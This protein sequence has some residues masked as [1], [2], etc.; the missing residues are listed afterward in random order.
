VI[1]S[2]RRARERDNVSVLDGLALQIMYFVTV[3]VD[4]IAFHRPIFKIYR[5]PPQHTGV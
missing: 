1:Q 2:K 3:I 4:I 5:S